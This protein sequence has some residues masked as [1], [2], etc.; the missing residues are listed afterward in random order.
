MSM[1]SEPANGRHVLMCPETGGVGSAH[2]EVQN[3]ERET[4]DC[5]AIAGYDPHVCTGNYRYPS[6]ENPA[7]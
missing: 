1:R 7:L 4:A 3:C 6:V 2:S 5:T